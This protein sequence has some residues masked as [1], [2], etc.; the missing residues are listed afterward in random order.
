M[1][2]VRTKRGARLL[3]GGAVLSE[4]LASPGPT[5]SLFDLLAVCIQHLSPGPRVAL[6]GFAGGGLLAPLRALGYEG[7]V[8]A[9]D[10]DHQ[11]VPL[12]WE[13]SADW[14]GEVTI[15][16]SDAAAWLCEQEPFDLILEDLSVEGPEGETK[17][18]VSWMAM[19]EILAARR[20]PRGV[21][22]TNLLPVP[23]QSWHSL[24]TELSAPFAEARLLE[25]TEYENRILIC[26]E[27]LPEARRL[28]RD[29]RLTMEELGSR[30]ARLFRSRTL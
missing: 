2:V 4:I 22:V 6:L 9:V 15:A 5:H 28:T 26:G 24:Q 20:K 12:F 1:K 11:A 18:E 8:S 29:F 23:G 7:P 16:E 17:P 3:Q 14:A 27:S 21:V 30:Q 19:P 10:L 25:L 13:L